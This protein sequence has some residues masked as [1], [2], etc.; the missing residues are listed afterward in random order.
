MTTR[1]AHQEP[2]P[3]AIAGTAPGPETRPQLEPVVP[4]RESPSR[5]GW[6][7]T[8][9]KWTAFAVIAGVAWYFYPQWG[10][11]V[12]AW[13]HPTPVAKAPP[14][15][16][17]VVVAVAPVIERNFDLY[18]NALGTITAFNTVTVRSRVEGEVIKVAFTEGQNVKAGDLL[19]E[20]DPRTYRMQRDQVLAQIARDE[21]TLKLAEVTLSRQQ[22]LMRSQA[23][24]PQLVDQQVAQV[25]QARAALQLDRAM[26]DNANLLIEYCRITA[27]ID[28]R[29]GLRL[30]DQGNIVQANSA[31]GLAVITQL[32]PISLVFTIPQD[33]IPRVQNEIRRNGTL[34]VEAYDR[35]FTT[36]L[37]VGTLTAVDNQV[38][39]TTG[40]LRL[41]A[42]FSNDDLTLFPNQFVNARLKVETLTNATVVPTASL[43]RGPDRT[44]V[45]VVQPDQTVELRVV[46]PGPS[47][48]SET[49]ILEGVTPGEEVVTN[50]LD[51]LQDKAK[52]TLP[53]ARPEAGNKPG[54]ETPGGAPATEKAA[55]NKGTA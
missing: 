27:P 5:N 32:Q 9:L 24:T 28:G 23:S 29:I 33:D 54:S 17:P 39:S 16:R 38:D 15:A 41:K 1:L 10:P 48:G 25:N 22:E 26:L 35:D 3:A 21:A 55:V 34:E 45:Y 49:A 44:F 30:V 13:L 18:L 8:I 4:P 36:R 6:T 53:G 37:G 43:Q 14:K 12:Q 11:H 52:I 7:G 46:K 50:G 31:Q 19:A 2:R 51:K 40:T 47:E 20:I 42:T